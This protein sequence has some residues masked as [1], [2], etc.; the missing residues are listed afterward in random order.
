MPPPCFMRD[1][2]S[3]DRRACGQEVLGE[4]ESSSP[5]VAATGLSYTVDFFSFDSSH[6]IRE[7][8]TNGEKANLPARCSPAVARSVL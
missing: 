8:K 4:S 5:E 3:Q 6:H 1:L 7:S 2:S